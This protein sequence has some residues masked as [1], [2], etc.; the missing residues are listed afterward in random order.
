[1]KKIIIIGLLIGFVACKESNNLAGK[2]FCGEYKNNSIE[3]SFLSSTNAEYYI[4][5]KGNFE[6]VKAGEIKYEIDPVT[7][8]GSHYIRLIYGPIT[9]RWLWYRNS[10]YLEGT[11][12]CLGID[13]ITK[14]SYGIPVPDLDCKIKI[15][16]EKGKL[17]Q[18]PTQ[19]DIKSK[20]EQEPISK[21]TRKA[22]EDL[23]QKLQKMV[24][25][26]KKKNGRAY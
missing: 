4:W 13:K 3:I 25:K 26:E 22:M 7:A 20:Q 16:L 17:E 5:R 14:E 9:E 6:N 1:M 8:D 15:I 23:L 24:D 21:E 10:S 18:K 2:T 19:E 12:Y 11:P